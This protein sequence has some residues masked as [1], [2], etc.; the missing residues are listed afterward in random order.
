M[1]QENLRLLESIVWIED[2]TE[3]LLSEEVPD[4]HEIQRLNSEKD[5]LEKRLSKD[6]K[7][8]KIEKVFE[9]F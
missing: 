4:L 3:R 9:S 8:A 6:I 5:K 2:E 7:K 1:S